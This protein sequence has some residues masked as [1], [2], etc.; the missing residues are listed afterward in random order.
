MLRNEAREDA[1]TSEALLAQI[2]GKVDRNGHA[3]TEMRQGVLHAR[4]GGGA[5]P[6]PSPRRRGASSIA[7]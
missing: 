1:Q 3:L 5:M 2:S 4:W 6:P 7:A